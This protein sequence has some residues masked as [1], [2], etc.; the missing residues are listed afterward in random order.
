MLLVSVLGTLKPSTGS[1]IPLDLHGSGKDDLTQ[2]A[3]DVL[4]SDSVILWLVP[5]N[6]IWLIQL[7]RRRQN[8][9]RATS[10]PVDSRNEGWKQNT[11]LVQEYEIHQYPSQPYQQQHYQPVAPYLG[12]QQPVEPNQSLRP[13]NPKIFFATI[14]L[15]VVTGLMWILTLLTVIKRWQQTFITSPTIQTY[16]ESSKAV[17]DPTLLGAMPSTCIDWL[18]SGGPV[19]STLLD[20]DVDEFMM[21]AVTTFQLLGCSAVLYTGLKPSIPFLNKKAGLEAA[22]PFRQ[23]HRMLKLS[24]YATFITLAIPALVTGIWIIVTVTVGSQNVLLQ[25]TNDLTQTGGC[26][27]AIVNM[28]KKWGYWDVQYELPYRIIMSIFGAT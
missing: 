28:N 7:L 22:S 14:V 12:P 24:A 15:A 4:T 23:T 27:F 1:P 5:F 11:P 9:Y 10:Y 13:S 6:Y 3:N 19:S 17:A 18:K 2:H 20:P 16:Y 25:Y 8:Y 21:V 26:T